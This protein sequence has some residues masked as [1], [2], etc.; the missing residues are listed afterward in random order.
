MP[1]IIHTMHVLAVPNVTDTARFFQDAMGFKLVPIVDE[2]WRLLRRDR[3]RL[4]IGECPDALAPSALGDHNYFG[5]F[6]V[7]DIDA[8]AAEYAAKGIAFRAAV[9]DKPWG[10][11]EFA[12]ETPDGH[13]I[14]FGQDID[15]SA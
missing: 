15:G 10:M 4:M 2:G 11:R 12:L 3:C 14:M 6:V 5:Y 9:A 1:E 13:R 8:L 7:D